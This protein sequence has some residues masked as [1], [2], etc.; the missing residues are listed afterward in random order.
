MLTDRPM[1]R[2]GFLPPLVLQS[3]AERG[4]PARRER[5]ERVLSRDADFRSRRA[6]AFPEKIEDRSR[7]HQS[8]LTQ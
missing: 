8:T 3:V 1:T 6:R 4:T 5:V 7:S 2:P